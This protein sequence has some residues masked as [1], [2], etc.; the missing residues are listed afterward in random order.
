MSIHQLHIS[1]AALGLE[2]GDQTWIWLAYCHDLQSAQRYFRATLD[3]MIVEHT[4]GNTQ[5][6][7]KSSTGTQL[8]PVNTPFLFLRTEE[9]M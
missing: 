9:G 6:G 5:S 8:V 4:A 3:S 7:C 2:W 1:V